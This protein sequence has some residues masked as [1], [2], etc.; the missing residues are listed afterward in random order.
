MRETLPRILMVL[1]VC[2]PSSA[3]TAQTDKTK[4]SQAPPAKAEPATWLLA[5][6]EGECTSLSILSIM[7]AEF[8]DV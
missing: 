7:G 2:L 3:H 8:S 6:R 5:G 1:L 4:I